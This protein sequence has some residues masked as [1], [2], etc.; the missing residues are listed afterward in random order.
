MS[1]WR[2]ARQRDAL[3]AQV[4]S[5]E[6][7]LLKVAAAWEKIAE[8]RNALARALADFATYTACT[9]PMLSV[10]NRHAHAIAQARGI[11]DKTP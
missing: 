3:L 9:D 2:I 4:A 7:E 11:V 5:Q 10:F 6:A 8:E 1:A